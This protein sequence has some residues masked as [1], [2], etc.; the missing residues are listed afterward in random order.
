MPK[1]FFKLTDDV[2]LPGPWALGHP[3][4]Q[5]GRKLDA[6]VALIVSEESKEALER[7]GLH[8]QSTRK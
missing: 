8:L 6:P 5:E 1:R 7:A 3:L 4:D 2:Y